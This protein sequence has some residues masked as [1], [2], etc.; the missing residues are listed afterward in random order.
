MSPSLNSTLFNEFQSPITQKIVI[1]KRDRVVELNRVV[2]PH[3]L[4]QDYKLLNNFK[5]QL[6]LA[7][8]R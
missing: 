2:G 1:S 8:V 4:T 5:Y 7:V 6:L 3:N